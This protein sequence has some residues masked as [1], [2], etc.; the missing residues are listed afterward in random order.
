MLINGRRGVRR[1]CRREVSSW[2]GIVRWE[3]VVLWFC[4]TLLMLFR[5][6]GIGVQDGVGVTICAWRVVFYQ[7]NAGRIECK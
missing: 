7:S 6:R 5:T 1:C 4:M 2:F 3:G